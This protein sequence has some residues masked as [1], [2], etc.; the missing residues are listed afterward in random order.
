MRNKIRDHHRR[1]AV[2]RWV[3]AEPDFSGMPAGEAGPDRQVEDRDDLRRVEALMAGLPEGLRTP[4]F[5]SAVEGMSLAEIGDLMGLSAKAVEVRVYRARKK[6]KA[7][8]E[9]E[10]QGAG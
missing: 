7:Q 6:L 3:G 4:L 2:L 8:F 10:G 5:L 9:D 1:R